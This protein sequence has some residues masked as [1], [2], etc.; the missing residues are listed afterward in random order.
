MFGDIMEIASAKCN[1]RQNG[2]PKARIIIAY[3]YNYKS[4]HLLCV[5]VCLVSYQ[6]TKFGTGTASKRKKIMPV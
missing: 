6:I 5:C 2:N 3:K 4:L 1:D